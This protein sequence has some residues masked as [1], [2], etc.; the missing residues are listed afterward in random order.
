LVPSFN[1]CIIAR[2]ADDMLTHIADDA[3]CALIIAAEDALHQALFAARQDLVLLICA[4]AIIDAQ[5]LEELSEDME[6]GLHDQSV[7][8]RAR[9]H[10]FITR[11]F[12]QLC[13]PVGIVALRQHIMPHCAGHRS[14]AALAGLI[15][16]TTATLHVRVVK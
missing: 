16:K 11:L 10:N 3:G 7:V 13:R 12:P 4:G 14:I 2:E 15:G 6:T 9:P 5:G 1:V 8:I